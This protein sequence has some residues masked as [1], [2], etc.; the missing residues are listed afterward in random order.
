MKR[1]LTITA[2]L[3]LLTGALVGADALALHY[4]PFV[5]INPRTPG[6][7]RL[8]LV[9]VCTP[10]GVVFVLACERSRLLAVCL[11]ALA[12]GALS[13]LV[14]FSV[15]GGAPDYLNLGRLLPRFGPGAALPGAVT[16][17]NLGDLTLAVGIVLLP[18]AVRALSRS[19]TAAEAR[20]RTSGRLSH[21]VPGSR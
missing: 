1:A 16:L 13:N 6:L 14:C 15:F 21:P 12:G 18:F 17:F 5:R 9:G 2:A 10:L 11:L 8:L 20:A 4:A 7:V 19:L 3:A